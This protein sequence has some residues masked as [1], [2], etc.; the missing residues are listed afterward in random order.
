[1]GDEIRRV[2]LLA[3]THSAT[4]DGR[5]LPD[6]VLGA[7]EGLDLIVHL[8]DIGRKAILDRLG[9]VAP[10]WVPV[11]RHKGYVPAGA[12][13][14][15]VKVVEGPGGVAGLAFNLAQPD[16]LI[17]VSNDAVSFDGD[18]D[19]LLQKRFKRPVQAVAFGGTHTPIVETYGGVLFVNPGSPNMPVDGYP[20]AVAVLD[21]AS[22]TAEVVEIG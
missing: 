4:A 11:P 13:A 14:P 15:P 12:D 8:G 1:M 21:L 20:G 5:D 7:F 2:G 9:E 10:V 19:A 3:D 16:K 18:Q 22:I 6:S 17:A